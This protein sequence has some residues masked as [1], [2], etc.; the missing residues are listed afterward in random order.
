MR[1]QPNLA[2]KWWILNL[3]NKWWILHFLTL[4]FCSLWR[5]LIQCFSSYCSSIMSCKPNFLRWVSCVCVWYD[6]FLITVLGTHHCTTSEDLGS[7]IPISQFS[8]LQQCCWLLIMM[9]VL[10]HCT[11]WSNWRLVCFSL[12][13]SINWRNFNFSVIEI[14]CKL[15]KNKIKIPAN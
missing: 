11:H 15:Q 9:I 2:N 6:V 12:L 10:C 5:S 13:K 3:A 1:S 8:T 7:S 4:Y 14:G